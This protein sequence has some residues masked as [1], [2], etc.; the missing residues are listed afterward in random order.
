[1]EI[2]KLAAQASAGKYSFLAPELVLRIAAEV[3]PKYKKDRDRVKAVKKLLHIHCG[4]FEND[5]CHRE[6]GEILDTLEAGEPLG[7]ERLERLCA[8]H[9]STRERLPELSSF[10][11]LLNSSLEEPESIVDVGCGFAPFCAELLPGVR[12]YHASDIDVRSIGLIGRY[13]DRLGLRGSAVALDAV[14]RTPEVSADAAFMF[15]LFPVLE[16]QQKGRGFRLMEE[17]K[18]GR[19]AL[20]FPIRSLGGHDRGMERFYSETFESGLPGCFEVIC[21]E[22]VGT[23]L[24]YVLRK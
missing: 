14:S 1:M 11:G 23:E 18:V 16:A 21:K 7:R 2:E 9:A 20:S 13:F 19:I 15:K 6:A 8:L 12:E 17:L 22:V 24:L 5:G 3:A 4:A 10:Y